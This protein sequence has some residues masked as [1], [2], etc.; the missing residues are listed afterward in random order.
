ME[1][2]YKQCNFKCGDSTT[3]AWI[4]EKYAVVGKSGKFK[5]I[6]DDKRWEIISV[7]KESLPKNQITSA[8]TFIAHAHPTNKMRG[9]K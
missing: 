6:G 5:D 1:D 7:S 4:E 2:L 8:Y 9:N 3:T